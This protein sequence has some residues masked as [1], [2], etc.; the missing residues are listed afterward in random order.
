MNQTI[1]RSALKWPEVQDSEI[2]LHMSDKADL[3]WLGSRILRV[4]V[5]RYW[6]AEGQHF[7]SATTNDTLPMSA[8]D[9]IE[10]PRSIENPRALS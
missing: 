7:S 6:P 9:L 10:R 1:Q 5:C 3:R 8:L 2:C 4:A